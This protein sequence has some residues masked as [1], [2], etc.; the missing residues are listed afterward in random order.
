MGLK[1]YA[2]LVFVALCGRS[3]HYYIAYF[4]GKGFDI[5]FFCPFKKKSA[6]FFFVFGWTG[7]S[8]KKVKVVPN[9]FWG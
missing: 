2:S 8:G 4:V 9:N 3:A 6:N 5:T 7:L 1:N